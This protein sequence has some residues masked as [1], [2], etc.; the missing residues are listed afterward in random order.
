M[1]V[2]SPFMFGTKKHLTEFYFVMQDPFYIRS[3]CRV[4]TKVESG[5][6]QEFS[7]VSFS[8]D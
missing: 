1:C 3:L 7:R 4:Q 2:M 6:Y 5:F 8:V